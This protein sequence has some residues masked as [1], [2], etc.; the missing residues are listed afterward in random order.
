[1]SQPLLALVRLVRLEVVPVHA[2]QECVG[3]DVQTPPVL[4]LDRSM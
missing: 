2:I 1:M 4:N 3:V